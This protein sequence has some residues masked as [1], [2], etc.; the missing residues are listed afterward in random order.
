M[1]ITK[2]LNWTELQYIR[3]TS[4]KIQ[5]LKYGSKPVF[6]QLKYSSTEFYL[7]SQNMGLQS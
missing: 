5:Q 4:I 6:N 7:M 3:Y 1:D 2:W